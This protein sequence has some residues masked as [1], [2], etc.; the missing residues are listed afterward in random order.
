ML[1]RDRTAIVYGGS[2]AVGGAVAKAFAREGARVFL[3]ARNRERL[4]AVADEIASL[5]GKAEI[6]TLDATDPEAVE[7]HLATTADSAGPVKVMFNA[8]DWGDT[9][10]Q[11]LTEM[12][13]ARF[14]RP[15]QNAL[16]TWFYTGTAVGRHMARNGG[17]V[18]LGITANAGR[19]PISHVGGFGVACAAVEHYLRQLAVENGPDQVRVCWVRSPGSP[20]APGVRE[21]W[22]LRA[23]ELGVSFDDVHREFAKST[24]LRRIT[25]LAQVA[26]A[27]VLLASDLAAGMTATMANAQGGAQVD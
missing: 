11:P 21:A 25:A 9:Q 12:D 27:A 19:E 10:G 8:I 3:A 2:G 16:T 23:N 4:Q 6:A 1:L 24:P 15:V 14:L 22:Q 18:I 20:D 26:D 5:G 13:F 7:A 17:G